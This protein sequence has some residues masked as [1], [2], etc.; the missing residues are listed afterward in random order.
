MALRLCFKLCAVDIVQCRAIPDKL[1]QADI[2]ILAIEVFIAA[3][4]C[5]AVI[6]VLIAVTR[7]QIDIVDSRLGR[8][9]SLPGYS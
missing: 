9:L 1:S 8:R 5:G 7:I 3:C 4:L 6:N 2:G